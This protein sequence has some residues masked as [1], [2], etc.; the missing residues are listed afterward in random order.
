[1]LEVLYDESSK[2]IRAWNA[3]REVK[4][5]LKP[6]EGQAVVSFANENPPA[7]P[8]DWYKVDLANEKVVGNPDYQAEVDYQ[9]QLAAE[10]N[11]IHV[12]AIKALKNW[13]SLTA[14][15]KD[16]LLKQLVKWALWKDGWLKLGV[17]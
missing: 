10:F 11:D 7:A 1:M 3:D 14:T 6:R 4:G 9:K 8:S 12:A 13:D 5:N 2:I 16:T 17:L 15:Q